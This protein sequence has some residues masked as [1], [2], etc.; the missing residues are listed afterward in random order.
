MKKLN[1][2]V[3]INDPQLAQQYANGQTQLINN[4][5]QINALQ[6]QI[7]KI[8][9]TKVQ[10]SKKMAEIE[11]KA[12]QNQGTEKSPEQTQIDQAAQAAQVAAT[13]AATT[14]QGNITSESLLEKINEDMNEKEKIQ[15]E[16][17]QLA[18]QLVYLSEHGGEAIEIEELHDEIQVLANQLKETD[19]ETMQ[20]EL[21]DP[22]ETP[23][24]SFQPGENSDLD[25]NLDLG[26]YPIDEADE[27][28]PRFTNMVGFPYD[29]NKEGRAIK[30]HSPIRSPRQR[31]LRPWSDVKLDKYDQFD[32]D[33]TDLEDDIEELEEEIKYELEQYQ[34]PNYD[35]IEGE[36]EEFWAHMAENEREI[37]NTG[38]YKNDEEKIKAL[39]DVGS[40]NPKDLLDNYYY[41]YPEYDPRLIKSKKNINK[42]VKKIQNQIDKLNKKIEK[43]NE[44]R[45]KMGWPVYKPPVY[46][47]YNPMSKDNFYNLNEENTEENDW[48]LRRFEWQD[49]QIPTGYEFS[50]VSTWGSGHQS[51]YINKVGSSKGIMITGSDEMGYELFS[52]KNEITDTA[53][54]KQ[55][56]LDKTIIM[57]S[58]L[59]ETYVEMEGEEKRQESKEDYLDE[60]YVFYVKINEEDN[61]FIGKIFKI[62]PD[63]DWYGII[64]KGEDDSFEKISYEPEYD[65]IDI[66]EFLG[67]S[68]D[69]IEIIDIHEF[70]EYIEDDKEL[71]EVDEDVIGGGSWPS[72]SIA[73]N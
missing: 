5:K 2:D 21:H 19:F 14:A 18:D 57:L 8:E 34:S 4:D 33:I 70:N 6:Q 20:S 53:T 44:Q 28:E 40:K 31:K 29:V 69:N 7:N 56:A 39:K 46:D 24:Q 63:G 60:D 42:V 43:K 49:I 22:Q 71:P 54:T 52:N 72:N 61:E 25:Q 73:S 17:D 16:I 48:Y 26:E 37:L 35:G 47:S 11:Q 51:P 3:I 68:Y 13:N 36:M 58:K 62:S 50:G 32:R 23:W 55:E 65:E 1:E 15:L 30:K 66:I 64:K 27:E 45:E 67:D 10:I 38:M 12:A 41:Y 9:Q 59:H